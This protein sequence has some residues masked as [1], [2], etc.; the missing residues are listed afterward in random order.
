MNPSVVITPSWARTVLAPLAFG[1][2]SVFL[3]LQLPNL[4]ADAGGKMPTELGLVLFWS[5]L[6]G[7]LLLA[8][9]TL[10]DFVRLASN[11]AA[12]YRAGDSLF[13]YRGDIFLLWRRGYVEVPLEG[14]RSV[15]DHGKAQRYGRVL[16]VVRDEQKDV[17]VETFYMAGRPG[18]IVLRLS[19]AFGLS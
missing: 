13:F 6:A 8:A 12:V 1:S 18:E 16:R 5:S 3:L 14:V 19:R 2:M 17:C 7:C 10:Y 15:T 11:G 4:G 9:C